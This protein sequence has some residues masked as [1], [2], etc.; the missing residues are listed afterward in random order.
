MLYWLPSEQGEEVFKTQTTLGLLSISQSDITNSLSMEGSLP[1]V[2]R[3]SCSNVKHFSFDCWPLI[4]VV[5]ILARSESSAQRS[6]IGAKSAL[7][8]LF[9]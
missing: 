1:L 2:P 8:R 3:L 6:E 4:S 9:T 7:L 5:V